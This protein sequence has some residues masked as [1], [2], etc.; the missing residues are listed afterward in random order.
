MVVRSWKNSRYRNVKRKIGDYRLRRAPPLCSV[1]V[2]NL[3]QYS[4]DN[5]TIYGF[6]QDGATGIYNEDQPTDLTALN[7]SASVSDREN[8]RL[9]IIGWRITM[10]PVNTGAVPIIYN[11]AIIIPKNAVN[12]S[13]ND[14]LRGYGN[15]RG[16]NFT[17]GNQS[18]VTGSMTPINTDKFHV[19][20]HKKV[21][22]NRQ[23]PAQNW[24]VERNNHKLINLWV[25]L[26][27]QI[28]YDSNTEDGATR[29]IWLIQWANTMN[30]IQSETGTTQT[31]VNQC[32]VLTYFRDP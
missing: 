29:P 4:G 6:A 15:Q 12:F 9:N 30:D 21:F 16:E 1:R 19:L 24:N 28:F 26:R 17:A 18:W 31:F 20:M 8:H 11:V 7:F 10:C 22:I 2:Q 3:E 27:R 25:P 14:F 5:K 13:R 32:R 23:E